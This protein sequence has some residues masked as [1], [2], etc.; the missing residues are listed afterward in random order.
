VPER[1][2][3]VLGPVVASV[4]EHAP[5]AVLVVVSNPVDNMTQLTAPFAA[6]GDVPAIRVIGSETMLDT[7]LPCAARLPLRRGPQHVARVRAGR[8]RR[9]RGAHLVASDDRVW[10]VEACSY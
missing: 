10:P 8:A 2:A 3:A 4:P 5:D 1:N 7:A 6:R 9:C